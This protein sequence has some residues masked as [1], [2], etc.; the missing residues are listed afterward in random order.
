MEDY[1]KLPSP[2]ECLAAVDPEKLERWRTLPGKKFRHKLWRFGK[3]ETFAQWSELHKKL[4]KC[5]FF[6]TA[7]AEYDGRLRESSVKCAILKAL[8]NGKREFEVYPLSNKDKPAHLQ[9]VYVKDFQF[10]EAVK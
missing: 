10:T 4:V 9:M 2:M 6:G 3:S 5:E 7:T 8:E 1:F